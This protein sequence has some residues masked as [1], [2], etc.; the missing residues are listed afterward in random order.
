MTGITDVVVQTGKVFTMEH[1]LSIEHNLEEIVTFAEEDAPD[2]LTSKN[3]RRGSTMDNR[4]FW[5]GH[6]LTLQVGE[7][8]ETDFHTITRVR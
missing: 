8:V 6:V 4:W 3:I 5:T 7:S 1:M 2:W